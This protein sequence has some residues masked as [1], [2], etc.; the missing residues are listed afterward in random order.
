MKK[1]A[2]FMDRDG[3]VSEEIGYV[4]HPGRFKVFP[5]SGEAIRL[6]NE[7]GYLAI[8]VTNQAGVARGYFK[9]ELVHEV[10]RVMSNQLALYGA[11]LDAV[12]Y[13]PHHPQAGEA[14]YRLD[15]SCRK[16][17]A[18]M[19]LKAAE[20]FNI[21]LEGSWFVGDRYSDIVVAKNAGIKSAFV[22]SGY[23]RGELEYQSHLWEIQPD[24]TSET[25]LEAVQKILL[26]GE[27]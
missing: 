11:R 20:D 21:D 13:C 15:C 5:Y 2:I 19:I 18:G 3:T 4:N 23:G 24:L 16:P 27:A 1:R 25:L 26:E 6:I 22:L 14:P 17:K 12:Y 8:V 10:H 7:A 9:E